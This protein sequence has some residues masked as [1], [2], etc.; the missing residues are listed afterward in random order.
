M[1]IIITKT[2]IANNNIKATITSPVSM[3]EV[4]WLGH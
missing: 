2:K 3:I 1:N 4:L